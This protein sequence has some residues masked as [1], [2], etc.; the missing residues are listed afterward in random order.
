QKVL[1]DPRFLLPNAFQ[2]PRTA[3]LMVR[4]SF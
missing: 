2:G 1:K 3:R 4:W